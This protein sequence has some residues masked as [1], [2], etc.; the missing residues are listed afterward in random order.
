M[1]EVIC[2]PKNGRVT[3]EFA[4]MENA[5]ST[6]TGVP[7]PSVM[8]TVCALALVLVTRI[9]TTQD[10]VAVSAVLEVGTTCHAGVKA[11]A[12]HAVFGAVCSAA[13]PVAPCTVTTSADGLPAVA[14]VGCFADVAAP[15]GS[16]TVPEIL[17]MFH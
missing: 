3:S 15:V 14:K 5:L 2:A 12:P 6:V 4:G 17:L 13:M 8:V 10:V 11:V 7:C 9:A 16:A 1:P